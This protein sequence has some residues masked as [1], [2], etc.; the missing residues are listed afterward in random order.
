M[1]NEERGP[2]SLS[3]TFYFMQ[4]LRRLSFLAEHD[5]R[6]PFWRCGRR[7][8]IFLRRAPGAS[9]PSE[10]RAG[11]TINIPAHIEGAEHLFLG[12]VA[13]FLQ[14]LKMGRTGKCEFD[15]GRGAFGQHSRQILVDA[16]AGDMGQPPHAI[17]AINL[18]M[19]DSTADG[20]AW[21]VADF[22]S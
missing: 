7:C 12:D 4:R 21:L 22:V 18:R 9:A 20:C 3:M 11:T 13:E 2:R 14:M 6:S 17:S 10:F 8:K 16:A 19:I 15:H 5:L 1:T